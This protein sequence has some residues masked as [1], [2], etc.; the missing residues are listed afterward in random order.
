MAGSSPFAPLT[1]IVPGA[2]PAAAVEQTA[3]AYA[4]GI[5]PHKLPRVLALR[6]RGVDLTVLLDSREQA[7]AVAQASQ[8][9]FDDALV[10]YGKSLAIREAAVVRS[11]YFL[12]RVL[13]AQGKP[14]E[15]QSLYTANKRFIDRLT[16]SSELL[17]FVLDHY[18]SMLRKSSKP[19]AAARIEAQ[20]KLL[21]RK[22]QKEKTAEP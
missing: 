7:E 1:K 9:S 3:R 12:A 18:A 13:D 2:I 6:T 16:D 19:A 4:V 22:K 10:N 21:E 11:V 5:A 14:A 15:A 20:A 8:N 17:P